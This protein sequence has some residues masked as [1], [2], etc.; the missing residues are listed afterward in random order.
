MISYDQTESSLKIPCLKTCVFVTY[1]TKMI[2]VKPIIRPLTPLWTMRQC[3]NLPSFEVNVFK[4]DNIIIMIKV[5]VGHIY[6]T[7]IKCLF[8]IRSQWNFV[9]MFLK[10]FWIQLNKFRGK[11]C[12]LKTDFIL[13]TCVTFWPINNSNEKHTSYYKIEGI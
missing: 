7:L 3:S 5:I 1:L 4:G 13:R 12:I 8:F 6:E 9:W 11:I 10:A 2:W